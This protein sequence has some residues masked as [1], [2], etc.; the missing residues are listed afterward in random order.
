MLLFA[1]RA[2]RYRRGNSSTP[3]SARGSK[4]KS[5]RA[6]E[7]YIKVPSGDASSTGDGNCVSTWESLSSL[8]GNSGSSLVHPNRNK[9]P[10]QQ[11]GRRDEEPTPKKPRLFLKQEEP[12]EDCHYQT[13][14]DPVL[15]FGLK[16]LALCPSL[17]VGK[18]M[19]LADE[20]KGDS[21]GGSSSLATSCSLKNKR[22]RSLRKDN[23][24][25][26]ASAPLTTSR[27][28]SINISV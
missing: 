1:R 18:D 19:R 4:R 12:E 7:K 8:A 3:R 5:S 9:V 24:L 17:E 22:K 14:L 28:F 25:A 11:K 10:F 21:N 27:H 6:R 23:N 16:V 13:P 15:P 2:R 26:G 20:S